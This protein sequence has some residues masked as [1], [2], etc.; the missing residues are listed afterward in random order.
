MY[1]PKMKL[2]QEQRDILEG[3]QGETKAKIMETLVRYGDIFD[4]T[5]LV[6]VTHGKG[7]LVTSF[8]L[9]VIKPVYRIFDEMI[10]AGLKVPK[11]FSVDPRPLDYKNVKVNLLE[12]IIFDF[13]TNIYIFAYLIEVICLQCYEYTY[14][15]F[16]QNAI[17]FDARWR[18]LDKRA[19]VYGELG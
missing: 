18:I 17:D 14:S 10:A 13:I 15:C 6:E 12:R 1:E 7:H 19:F 11:G 16:R 9:S 8:G 3:K 4:A 5:E 2:T